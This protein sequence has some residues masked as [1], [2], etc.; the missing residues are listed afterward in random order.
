LAAHEHANNIK[1]QLAYAIGQEFPVS[2]RV[3]DSTGKEYSLGSFSLNDLTPSAI[4][5]RFQLQNPMYYLT[6]HNGHFGNRSFMKNGIK[7]YAWEDI[8][9]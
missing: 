1:V 7:Y 9:E 8:T 5:E 6:S 3:Y 4:I 2:Y